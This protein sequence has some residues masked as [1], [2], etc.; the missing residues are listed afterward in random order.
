MNIIARIIVFIV[1]IMSLPAIHH[2]NKIIEL[3]PVCCGE[4][5]EFI[6]EYKSLFGSQITYQCDKC[7]R[8]EQIP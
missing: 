4:T 3:S 6:G 5:M 8:I 1:G 2:V 7:K